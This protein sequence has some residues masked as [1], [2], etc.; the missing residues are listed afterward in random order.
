MKDILY[1]CDGIPFPKPGEGHV[2]ALRDGIGLKTL[3]SLD[4]QSYYLRNL[5]AAKKIY[6]SVIPQISDSELGTLC[7]QLNLPKVAIERVIYFNCL[8]LLAQAYDLK[9]R[10]ECYLNQH[11]V[12]HLHYIGDNN[13]KRDVLRE[14]CKDRDIIFS[15]SQSITIRVHGILSW[16]KN[17]FLHLYHILLP[18]D[19]L[20]ADCE[21][22]F[23]APNARM[24][25]GLL[26]V[27]SELASNRTVQVVDHARKKAKDSL[28]TVWLQS[29]SS[30]GSSFFIK[31]KV[32]SMISNIC[33]TDSAES[34]LAPAMRRIIVRCILDALPWMACVHRILTRCPNAIITGTFVNEEVLEIAYA[35]NHKTAVI[36]T[37]S[38]VEY[39]W[40][41]PGNHMYLLASMKDRERLLKEGVDPENIMICGHPLYH[42]FPPDKQLAEELNLAIRHRYGI[43][44]NEKLIVFAAAHSVPGL[45]EWESVFNRARMFLN[46][47]KNLS[48]IKLIIKLH[49]YEHR[50]KDYE[51]ILKKEGMDN[52]AHITQTENMNH[53]LQAAD[54]VVIL[55]STVGQESIFLGKPLMNLPVLPDWFGYHECGATVQAHSVEDVEYYIPR[56]LYDRQLRNR[57]HAGR[58]TFLK[59]Y[60]PIQDG[61]V[62]SRICD[63]LQG[64]K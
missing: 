26:P 11:N 35:T 48:G 8:I 30:W 32:E 33:L 61:K 3:T 29:F 24:T 10:V 27:I 47:I 41:C 5:T 14:I 18:A 6:I 51:A 9:H 54:A 20:S 22:L 46:G 40:H 1:L 52:K 44:G 19:K 53:L 4:G 36:Q 58:Q 60:F 62:V 21:Y 42:G 39:N 7:Q 25:R 56:M 2:F 50:I 17:K 55:E 59:H 23:F 12:S 31:K 28:G 13:W 57:L 34:L 63:V 64:L 45:T 15:F 16:I 49:P 38:N 43:E 37:C